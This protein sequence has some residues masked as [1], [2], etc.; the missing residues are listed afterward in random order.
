LTFENAAI[1]IGASAAANLLQE[2]IIRRLT[3]NS[4]PHDPAK[5]PSGIAKASA[6]L[7]HEFD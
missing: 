1:G 2:F 4:H 7:I 5:P 6:M 3:P